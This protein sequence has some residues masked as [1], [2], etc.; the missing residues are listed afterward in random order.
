MGVLE[1]VE[2]RSHLHEVVVDALVMDDLPCPSEVV[3]AEGV[4]EVVLG[5]DDASDVTVRLGLLKQHDRLGR[6]S[7]RLQSCTWSA[8]P[9]PWSD[10]I[11]DDTSTTVAA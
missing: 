6:W 8:I 2:L 10:A 1:G 5:V 7:Q 11:A 9:W 3:V 4:V